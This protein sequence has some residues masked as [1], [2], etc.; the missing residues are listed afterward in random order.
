MLK[1]NTGL[2]YKLISMKIKL[3]ASILTLLSLFSC[4]SETIDSDGG[5]STLPT[6]KSIYAGKGTRTISIITMHQSRNN[7]VQNCQNFTQTQEKTFDTYTKLG[8]GLQLMWP[9]NLL[10]GNTIQTGQ[11]ASIPI[12][13]DGRNPIEVKVDAFSSNASTPTFKSIIDP[14]AGKVQDAL[15][16]I[17]NSYFDSGTLFPANYSIDVQRTFTKKQLNL[18]L[19]IGYTGSLQDLSASMGFNFNSA[20]T[21]YAVTV[22]QKFFNVS[23]APKVGLKGNNGWVKQD[24][25]DSELSSYISN[26]NPA[27]YVSSVTYGRLYTLVYESEDTATKLEQALTFAFKSPAASVTAQQ[28]LEYQTT[29]QNATVY[30]KQLG[31]NASSGLEASLKALGGDFDQ[32][33][34]FIVSGAEASKANPGYPIEYTATNV[35]SELPVT[36][37]VQ[38]TFDYQEC[39]DNTYKLVVKNLDFPTIPMVLRTEANWNSSPYYLEPGE[40]VTLPYNINLNSFTYNNSVISQID[41]NNGG[42]S[43]DINFTL[44][45]SA[46]IIYRPNYSAYLP[47]VQN[48]QNI[49]AATTHTIEDGINNSGQARLVAKKDI[50][51]NTLI[52]EI[53]KKQ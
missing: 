38:S 48:F 28:K 51:S 13:S 16:S 27:T 43:D 1:Y 44:N 35:V 37:N 26:N 21:Y 2:T 53:Q 15:G 19:S 40:Y 24:Y 11:L 47:L 39:Y 20:K 46:N 31:G 9:G 33:R 18:A 6:S 32:I 29:L 23:V 4:A 12:G 50:S 52:I 30:A 7:T 22:K 25:P 45:G 42:S 10:Q 3:T 49:A 5:T 41:L 36:I 14:T 34:Q 17:L 8:T